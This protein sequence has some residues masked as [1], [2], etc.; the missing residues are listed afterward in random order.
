MWEHVYVK[1]PWRVSGVRAKLHDDCTHI[2]K[3]QVTEFPGGI[4]YTIVV[5]S[6]VCC[7]LLLVFVALF[8]RHCSSN[9][10]FCLFWLVHW[11]LSEEKY[12][13]KYR[14]LLSKFGHFLLWSVKR[15]LFYEHRP[16][17]VLTLRLTYPFL[18]V[19]TGAFTHHTRTQIH[20]HTNDHTNTCTYVNEHT[21]KSF[22]VLESRL[23]SLI[24]F[25]CCGNMAP[26]TVR[27]VSCNHWQFTTDLTT[28]LSNH[29]FLFPG[30]LYSWVRH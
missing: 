1:L 29:V 12:L 22:S 25:P 4:G 19:N 26:C 9:R 2:R 6:T 15:L 24:L 23:C 3:K 8:T 27:A 7:R 18:G 10:F 13:G 20:I 17:H 5:I 16:T 14:A 21:H 28:H 11:F 30:K